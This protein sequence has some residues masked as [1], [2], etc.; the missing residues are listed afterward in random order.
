MTPTLQVGKHL[1]FL[2]KIAQQ[3]RV[4]AGISLSIC[5]SRLYAFFPCRLPLCPE[6]PH[7]GACL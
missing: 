7:L 3:V 5:D 6:R 1:S 4:G 2:L